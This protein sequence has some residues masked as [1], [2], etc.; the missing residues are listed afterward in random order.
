MNLTLL[1]LDIQGK[2]FEIVTDSPS[3]PPATE[4]DL[5]SVSKI[6][7]WRVQRQKLADIALTS[8]AVDEFINLG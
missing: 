8:T 1:T 2:I 5:R 6:P 4:Q 3:D 7:T